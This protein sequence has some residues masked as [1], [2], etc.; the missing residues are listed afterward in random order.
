MNCNGVQ[1]AGWRKQAERWW[2][3]L[4]FEERQA[5]EAWLQTN[6]PPE[7]WKGSREQWAYERMDR[8]WELLP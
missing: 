1:G 3:E 2:R 8:L 5:V 6:A 4:R 7:W